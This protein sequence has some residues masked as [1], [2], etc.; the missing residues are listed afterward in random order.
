M[1]TRRPRFDLLHVEVVI[2]MFSRKLSLP[3]LHP[4]NLAK[5]FMFRYLN[6]HV[7]HKTV[8]QKAGKKKLFL[9]LGL[10]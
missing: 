7:T 6:I 4:N 5:T 9:F 8:F 2:A 10:C 1:S 3:V